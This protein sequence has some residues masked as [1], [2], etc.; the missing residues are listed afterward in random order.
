MIVKD[1]CIGVT[2]LKVINTPETG[3]GVARSLK[4]CGYKVVG[5]SETRLT[6]AICSSYFDFVYAIE[7]FYLEDINVFLK[8]ISEVKKETG[9]SII[10][11]CSDGEVYFFS[12]HKAV[13]EEIGIKVLIP[14]LKSLK[15]T[16]KLNLNEMEKQGINVPK[17]IIVSEK[18]ELDG[19]E[20]ALGFP[21]V[22]KGVLKDVYIAKD[23]T[24][25]FIYFDR[26]NELLH[27][28]RGKVLFQ[29][30]LTGD[31]YCAT[32]VVDEN[33]QLVNFMCMKKLG[34]DLKGATWCGVT[35]K[36]SVLK[37]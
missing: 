31:Y 17:T 19:L 9:L 29:K 6:S 2:G 3:F 1:I 30:Y 37:A 24:D 18:V 20:E 28:G 10:I 25:L 27:N 4:Q 16:S 34:I 5:I 32:G 7:S 11:P 14:S 22:C 36:E 21:I 23:K 15:A 35:V 8:K 26:I 12:K 13:F 33:N